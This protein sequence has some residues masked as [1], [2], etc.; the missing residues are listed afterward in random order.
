MR[1]IDGM[2]D[3]GAYARSDEALFAMSRNEF[4]KATELGGA[5]TGSGA[6]VDPHSGGEEQGGRQ[7]APRRG[8]QRLVSPLRGACP[9][10]YPHGNPERYQ[11]TIGRTVPRAP[12]VH[13]RMD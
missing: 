2:A 4:R 12:V 13:A 6:L 9:N 5:E 3:P 7:P 11:E 10:H 1:Q 8:I